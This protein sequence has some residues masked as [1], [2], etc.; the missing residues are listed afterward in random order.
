MSA[1]RW[2][3]GSVVVGLFAVAACAGDNDKVDR[4]APDAGSAQVDDYCKKQPNCGQCAS[5]GRC[6]WCGD[7]KTCVPMAEGQPA[8]SCSGFVRNNQQCGGQ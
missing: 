3:L 4:P 5:E 6:G 2:F 7:S 8:P 1:H